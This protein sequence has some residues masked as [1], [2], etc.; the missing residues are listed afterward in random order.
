MSVTMLDCIKRVSPITKDIMSKAEV[1][2]DDLIRYLGEDIEKIHEIIIVGAGSSNTAA[3]TSFQFMEKVTGLQVHTYSANQFDKKAVYNHFALYLFVSQ[4]GTSTLVKEM[5]MKMNDLGNYTCAITESPE[6]PVAKAAKVHVDMG[7]GYEE[8]WYRT[9]GYCSSVATLMVIGLRIGLERGHISASAFN[10]YL[11]QGVA[12]AENHP[13]VCEKAVD[14]FNKHEKEL[15]SAKSFLIYG[16]GPLYGVALEGALK[17]LETAKHTLAIGYEAEDGLHG[18]TLGFTEGDVV[19][20]LN[21]GVNDDW[22]SQGVVQFSKHELGQG[23][24]FGENVIDED[25]LHFEVKGQDF[26]AL[27]FAPAVE[28]LAYML[29]EAVGTPVIDAEHAVNHVSEKYFETHR[30]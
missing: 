6:T 29:A 24:I 3:L 18:P 14:W 4:T 1:R 8:Y 2:T 20:A 21:D 5:V 7:C 12:A 28:I 16:A 30:G 27:E 19:I 26:R 11:N 10:E 22:M 13:V 9:I 25:D 23:Y 15:V 17:C